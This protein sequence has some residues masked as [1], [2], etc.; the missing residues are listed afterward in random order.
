MQIKLNKLV[1]PLYFSFIFLNCESQP[2]YLNSKQ[3]NVEARTTFLNG[4]KSMDLSPLNEEGKC[5]LKNIVE[6]DLDKL[7]DWRI[8]IIKDRFVVKNYYD[9]YLHLHFSFINDQTNHNRIY[10][11]S[12]PHLEEFFWNLPKYYEPKN[13]TIYEF[14]GPPDLIKVNS[15]LIDK[16]LE[17]SSFFVKATDV[18]SFYSKFHLVRHLLEEMLRPIF[19]NEISVGTLVGDI[20]NEFISGKI[21]RTVYQNINDKI[22]PMFNSE[23]YQVQVFQVEQVCYVLL[24]YSVDEMTSKIKVDFFIIPEAERRDLTGYDETTEYLECLSR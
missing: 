16:F 24:V 14:K 4:Y 6:N 3:F 11:I 19:P 10:F 5:I 21:S 13:D 7:N 20:E 2:S 15:I 17:S 23:N 9:D 12:L 1:A 8:A 22:T 18:K